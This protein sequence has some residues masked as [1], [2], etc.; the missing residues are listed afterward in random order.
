M[1]TRQIEAVT[2]NQDT[3]CFVELLLRSLYA[4]H[5]DLEGI[6]LT[7]LDKNSTDEM[8]HLTSLAEVGPQHPWQQSR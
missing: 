4:T 8:W 5:S 7:I 3:S 1:S 2:I 6:R